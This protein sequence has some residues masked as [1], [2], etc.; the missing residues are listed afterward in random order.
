MPVTP[1]HEFS[2]VHFMKTVILKNNFCLERV[3]KP[4]SL[5]GCIKLQMACGRL[6]SRNVRNKFCE[7]DSS[8]EL[9]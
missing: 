1:P 9:K 5:S 2:N 4:Q 6:P 3:E 8:Q 7:R